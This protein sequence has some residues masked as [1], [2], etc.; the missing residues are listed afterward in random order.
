MLDEFQHTKID[1]AK[2]ETAPAGSSSNEPAAAASGGEDP[3]MDDFAKHIQES[4]ADM[5]KELE[6]DPESMKQFEQLMQGFANPQEFNTGENATPAA[7]PAT[8]PAAPTKAPATANSSTDK[9]PASSS[10]KGQG[11][12]ANS[13]AAFQDTIRKTMERMKASS[14]SADE[15]A[16]TPAEDD[17]MAQLLKELASAGGEGGDGDDAFS[18]MLLGMMEQLTNKEILY[19][20][21]KEL[22]GKFDN[23]LAENSAAGKLKKEDEIRYK[24]QRK[25]VGEIVKRFEKQGYSDSNAEDR[26]YIVERMQ[27]MQSQGAPPPDLVGDMAG[28]EAMMGGMD[29]DC[30][31]Q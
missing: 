8:G 19:E 14:A 15:S 25:L 23:W 28:A 13:E 7:P 10:S 22:D 9:T 21:M 12:G 16:K 3:S 4:M 18:K 26:E 6:Q 1:P 27:Q 24:E 17:I 29:Q 30:A 11:A 20:P 31:Q 5:I 2:K